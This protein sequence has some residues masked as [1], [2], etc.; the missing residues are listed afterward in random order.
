MKKL[1]TPTLRRLFVAVAVSALAAFG[2]TSCLDELGMLAPPTLTGN[3]V[4]V[5]ETRAAVIITNQ[6][7]TIN[8][9]TATVSTDSRGGL[10]NS[11]RMSGAIGPLTQRATYLMPTMDAV[12]ITVDYSAQATG[13]WAAEQGS[14]SLEVS[15][16]LPRQL[17]E[18][19]VYRAR[20][21]EVVVRLA[22][23][24][25]GSMFPDPDPN[26]T[27]VARVVGATGEG[28]VPAIIPQDWSDRV[29]TIIVTNLTNNAV[30]ESAEF[31][32]GSTSFLMGRIG[33]RDRNS[34]G[35]G[36]GQWRVRLE[37]RVLSGPQANTVRRTDWQNIVVVRPSQGQAVL[38][39]YV[40]FRSFSNGQYG[41]EVA[42]SPMDPPAGIEVQPETPD[43]IWQF[44]FRIE[45]LTGAA[46]AMAVPYASPRPE[47]SPLTVFSI[48][49][50]EFR[51]D[52]WQ[53]HISG[54]GPR[55]WPTRVATWESPQGQRVMPGETVTKNLNLIGDLMGN[56]GPFVYAITIFQTDLGGHQS[57]HQLIVA[58]GGRYD[59]FTWRELG[60]PFTFTQG[61]LAAG[62][63][64]TFRHQW[65]SQQVVQ[66]AR[67]E[68]NAAGDI[69]RNS[70]QNDTNPLARHGVYVLRSNVG[71]WG[72]FN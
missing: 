69:W 35:L 47:G 13:V 49:V 17:E 10:D 42:P 21:G 20:S 31:T 54:V 6:S 58:R 7:R 52:Q 60:V 23:D 26:D 62:R 39:H 63:V 27:G 51:Q 12:R 4:I 41:I 14:V 70:H 50:E 44:P 56:A 15:L 66:N 72:T 53:A 40:H 65:D 45:N 2:A 19:L 57:L 61:D 48:R 34:I 8:V 29:S 3:F 32:M 37:Y 46:D 59:R 28:S 33:T 18:V 71:H 55:P 24:Q 1:K 64:I 43:V 11:I 67:W 36:P 30:V 9:T 5:D 38:E 25:F 22:R 16:P 68:F